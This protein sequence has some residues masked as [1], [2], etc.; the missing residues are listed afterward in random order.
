MPQARL[1][2]CAGSSEPSLIACARGT[3]VSLTGSFHRQPNVKP[4]CPAKGC[5]CLIL[6]KGRYDETF[7]GKDECKA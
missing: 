6:S 2:G 5:D 7:A 4:S 3:I 1:C